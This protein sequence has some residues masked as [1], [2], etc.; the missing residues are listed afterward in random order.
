MLQLQGHSLTLTRALSVVLGGDAGDFV[1]G[2]LYFFKEGTQHFINSGPT[3]AVLALTHTPHCFSE[4]SFF[5]LGKA[6]AASYVSIRVLIVLHHSSPGLLGSNPKD[7][8]G[9]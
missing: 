4:S 5:M 8:G 7:R 3:T 9:I 1:L 2:I 6:A